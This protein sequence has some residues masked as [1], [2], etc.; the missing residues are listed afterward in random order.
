MNYAPQ[1]KD[2]TTRAIVFVACFLGGFPLV[3]I[4]LILRPN[5]FL[6]VAPV[7]FLA[8]A[9]SF[10]RWQQFRCPRCGESFYRRRGDYNNMFRANCANCGLEKGSNPP[11]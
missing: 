7:W 2:L 3:G 5:L 10:L 8:F 4:V 6:Y 1:W 11:E 9:V